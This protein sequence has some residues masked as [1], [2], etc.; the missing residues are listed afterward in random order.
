MKITLDLDKDKLITELAY[1]LDA[2]DFNTF[3]LELIRNKYYS[4][5]DTYNQHDIEYL[6]Q[7]ITTKYLTT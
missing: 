1:R 4:T 6:I 7:Q 3:L 5:N 2:V